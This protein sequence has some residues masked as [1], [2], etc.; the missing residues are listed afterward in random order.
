M[1]SRFLPSIFP[2]HYPF[3]HFTFI[4]LLLSVVQAFC[5]SAVFVVLMQSTFTVRNMDSTPEP[6]PL[7][8]RGSLGSVPTVLLVCLP[9]LLTTILYALNAEIRYVIW[10]W[11]VMN[12]ATGLFKSARCLLIITIVLELGA[13]INNVRLG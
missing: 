3:S 12:A 13:S 9:L 5:P 6:P 7:Q 1:G 11:F 2:F 8:S 4:P 10:S